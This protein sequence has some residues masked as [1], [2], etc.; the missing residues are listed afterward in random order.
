MDGF[1]ILLVMIF[2]QLLIFVKTHQAKDVKWF[3]PVSIK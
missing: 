2:I 1:Y 3:Y